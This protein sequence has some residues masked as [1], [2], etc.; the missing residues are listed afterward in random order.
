MFSRD[1]KKVEPAGRP[2]SGKKGKKA[3]WENLFSNQQKQKVLEEKP[4]QNGHVAHFRPQRQPESQDISDFDHFSTSPSRSLSLSGSFPKGFEDL[5]RSPRKSGH[6]S[7]FEGKWPRRNDDEED[8]SL[9]SSFEGPLSRSGQSLN[10]SFGSSWSRKSGSRN[11]LNSSANLDKDFLLSSTHPPV[12]ANLVGKIQ[13]GKYINFQELLPENLVQNFKKNKILDKTEKI[14][15]ITKWIE[16]MGLYVAICSFV[17]SYHVQNLIAYQ[18]TILH[19]YRESRD[20]RAW[21]RYD[22]AFR[23]KASLNGVS[24]WS[25]IDESLWVLASSSE[26]R[27]SVLCEPCLSMMHDRHSCPLHPLPEEPIKNRA[28]WYV[29]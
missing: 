7:S 19:L 8:D 10:A 14:D 23:R 21:Q 18:S 20:P 1:K 17:N 6:N 3:A 26:T 22:V 2:K 24:D 25:N 29:F 27:K 11:S 12:K 16:C 13:E 4:G 9:D 28:M 15:D 5:W